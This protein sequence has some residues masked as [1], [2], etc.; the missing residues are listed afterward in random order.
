[1]L[2]NICIVSYIFCCI[3]VSSWEYYKCIE[4]IT[5]VYNNFCIFNCI[6]LRVLPIHW[7]HNFYLY[8]ITIIFAKLRRWGCFWIYFYRENFKDSLIKLLW[9]YGDKYKKFYCIKSNIP[10]E[11]FGSWWNKW[12]KI[13]RIDVGTRI[14]W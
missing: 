6:A 9:T 13:N 14:L 5:L 4:S 10:I 7:E 2:H 8:V 12:M 1:M 3:I 11:M